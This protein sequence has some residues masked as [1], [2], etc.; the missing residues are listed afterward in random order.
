MTKLLRLISGANNT[1]MKQRDIRIIPLAGVKFINEV[2]G[3]PT[4]I[5]RRPMQ[6]AGKAK[7]YSVPNNG[8]IIRVTIPEGDR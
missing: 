8:K 6:R 2:G 3:P 5:S 1:K 7:T 4:I